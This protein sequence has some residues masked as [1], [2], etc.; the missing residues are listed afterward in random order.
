MLK[1]L[2]V[3]HLGHTQIV[4]TKEESYSELNKSKTLGI[5]QGIVLNYVFVNKQATRQTISDQSGLPLSNVCGRVGELK[6]MGLL[7][8][9]DRI[10]SRG[11]LR[12]RR[13]GELNQKPEVMNHTE[14]MNLKKKLLKLKEVGSDFQKKEIKDL[15]IN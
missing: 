4:T 14:F 10:G 9:T 1:V 11:L 15:I 5:C 2:G 13:K 7:M 12:L 3:I 8:E 6:D